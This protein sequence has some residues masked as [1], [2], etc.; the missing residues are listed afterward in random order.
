MKNPVW[1][2]KRA[3]REEK[4]PREHFVKKM[5]CTFEEAPRDFKKNSDTAPHTKR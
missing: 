3:D 4:N 5:P 2:G 1:T